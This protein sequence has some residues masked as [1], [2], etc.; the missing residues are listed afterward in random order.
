MDAL[1]DG[2]ISSGEARS[3]QAGAKSGNPNR[4]GA[5]AGWG[6]G[7]RCPRQVWVAAAP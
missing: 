2:R 7:D 1:N 6:D 4:K 5:K 3:L